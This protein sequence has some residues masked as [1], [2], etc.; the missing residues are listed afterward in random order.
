MFGFTVIV[1]F[2][3]SLISTDTQTSKSKHHHPRHG[4]ENSF[5]K[6]QRP[7]F[8]IQKTCRLEGLNLVRR[9]YSMYSRDSLAGDRH[10]LYDR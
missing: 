9:E 8:S 7:E 2:Q 4:S 3:A 1:L 10:R 6:R 5:H